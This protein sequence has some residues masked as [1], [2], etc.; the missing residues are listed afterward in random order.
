MPVKFVWML[1]LIVAVISWHA[2]FAV[3]AY[4]GNIHD[5]GIAGDIIAENDAI[6]APIPTRHS[7]TALHQGIYTFKHLAQEFEDSLDEFWHYAIVSTTDGAITVANIVSGLALFLIGM[8]LARLLSRSLHRRLTRYIHVDRSTSSTLEKVIHY[9]FL[10]VM[11]IL[12]LDIAR[13]PLTAFTFIGGALAI[14]IGLGSQ[15]IMND[16]L[17]GFVVMIEQS[18]RVGDVIEVNGQAGAVVAIGAR[19]TQL[20]TYANIDILVPNSHLLENSIINWTLSEGGMIRTNVQVKALQ[21]HAPHY[22]ENTIY[23]AVLSAPHVVITNRPPQ[24]FLTS[25]ADGFYNYDIHFWI[26]ITGA[27]DRRQIISNVNMAI[28]RAFHAAR[29]RLANSTHY[30]WAKEITPKGFDEAE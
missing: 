15:K 23:R 17:S 5:G 6:A 27:I 14:G 4:E 12:A 28:I 16:V 3:S 20:C 19:H 29:I 22:V 7:D 11:T 26:D 18:I 30:Y 2:S 13:V 25:L 9:T 21:E 10:T 8:K 24:I 1:G